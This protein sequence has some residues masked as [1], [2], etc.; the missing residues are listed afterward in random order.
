[1]KG[2][3]NKIKKKG[4]EKLSFVPATAL[5]FFNTELLLLLLKMITSITGV[6]V[7]FVDG[8]ER[9]WRGWV[10]YLTAIFF[11]LYKN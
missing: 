3:K 1:M 4:D 5:Y 8:E 6:A 11:F 7:K 10:E 2:K 9:V